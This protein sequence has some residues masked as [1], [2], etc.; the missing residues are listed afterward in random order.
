MP[1]LF[2][3]LIPKPTP[4]KAQVV[5]SS[6]PSSRL[7]ALSYTHGFSLGA[8]AILI[9]LYFAEVFWF[10]ESNPVVSNA[11]QFAAKLIELAIL[12]SLSAMVL[13]YARFCLLG[14]DGLPYGLLSVTYRVTD[15]MVLL[16]EKTFWVSFYKRRTIFLGLFMLLVLLFSVLVGP[17][18]AIILLPTA[19]YYDFP[20]AFGNRTGRILFFRPAYDFRAASNS[21]LNFMF[22]SHLSANTT[23]N[24]TYCSAEQEGNVGD[25]S[26]PGGV[27]DDVLEWSSDADAAVRDRTTVYEPNTRLTYQAVT[28]LVKDGQ[29]L[30]LTA[31]ASVPNRHLI[32]VFGTLWRRNQLELLSGQVARAKKMQ[33]LSSKDSKLYQPVIQGTC[34]YFGDSRQVNSSALILQGNRLLSFDAVLKK[35]SVQEN[36]S[37]PVPRTSIDRVMKRSLNDTVSF[38]KTY[39]E[40]IE[41]S[42]VNASGQF[43]IGALVSSP[44]SVWEDGQFRSQNVRLLT[45][46]VFSAHWMPTTLLVDPHDRI[47]VQSN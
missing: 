15:I 25:T 13:H 1:R 17:A 38:P 2:R 29:N 39:V 46:C 10:E 16:K 30:T 4:N 32:W 23:F 40:W 45:P 43:S 27:Y 19:D 5:L 6:T 33:L 24:A 42:A 28:S 20:G 34:T 47:H 22:P 9:W 35:W 11:L 14:D 41:P 44:L 7:F 12:G 21:T 3:M 26:C 36:T 31:A 8:S 18:A 37:L